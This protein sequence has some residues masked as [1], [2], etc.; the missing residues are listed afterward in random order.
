[1]AKSTVTQ[2]EFEAGLSETGGF[3][4]LRNAGKM[5]DSPFGSTKVLP[6][7]GTVTESVDPRPPV[8]PSASTRARQATADSPKEKELEVHVE[9]PGRRRRFKDSTLEQVPFSFRGEYRDKADMVARSIQRRKSGL[10]GDRF[11]A[12]TLYRV[13]SEIGLDRFEWREG[14]LV[15][16]EAELKELVIERLGLVGGKKSTGDQS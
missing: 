15:Q 10:P 1:M 7:K 11:T 9:S 8:E 2:E 5:R 14:D 6:K 4:G 16:T 3:S 13:F 12:C